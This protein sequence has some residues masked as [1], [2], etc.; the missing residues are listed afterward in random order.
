M[1]CACSTNA[2][3]SAAIKESSDANDSY[4]LC[5]RKAIS[6]LPDAI[7]YG[8][9]YYSDDIVDNGKGEEQCK[10][11]AMSH[12]PHRG[13]S[14]LSAPPPDFPLED[15]LL[16]QFL[17]NPF[18]ETS[19]PLKKKTHGRLQKKQVPYTSGRRPHKT[20]KNSIS[21]A[22]R[23]HLSSSASQHS[24]SSRKTTPSLT[25]SGSVNSD[26]HG[27]NNPTSG[28]EWG[29]EQYHSSCSAK[30]SNQIRAM[31]QQSWKRRELLKSVRE[32]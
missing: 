23:H 10:E 13:H 26:V 21:A 32:V 12:T 3:V 14:S 4:A 8:N 6:T 19:P 18:P 7:L 5:R 24:R 29:S 31:L 30:A 9:W 17:Q 15:F 22:G 25:G 28:S 16:L 20:K 2:G 27:L 11:K 1:G